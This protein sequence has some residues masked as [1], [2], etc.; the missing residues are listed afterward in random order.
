MKGK[1]AQFNPSNPFFKHAVGQFHDEGIDEYTHEERPTT[2]IFHESPKNVLSKNNSPDLQFTYSVNPYQGCE[3]G[4]VYCYARNSHTYWGFSAGLDFER[5]IIV[6]D[7]VAAMLE[8]Q[9]SKVTW[10][11]QPIMLS[12][13]TDCYQPIEKDLK[14]TRGILE[15]MLKYRNPVSIITKNA[16]ILRDSDLLQALA[17]KSLVHVYFSITTLDESLRAKLEPRTATA[18]K[19]LTAIRELSALGVPVGIM[20]AP[21]I[22]GLN[23]TEIPAV[24]K[25][26]S[27]HGALAAGYTVVRL[28][29]QI[30]EIFEDWVK[31][32]FADRAEKTMNQIKELHGGKAN[33]TDWGRRLHGAGNYALMIDQLFQKSRKKHFGDKKMPPLN[34]NIFRKGG[35]YNLFET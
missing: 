16:L 29:G 25:S 21:I 7:K 13:N 9:L 28:N 10:K 23:D 30:K 8:A 3:H 24:L 1:G 15:V 11:P 20:N 6:K 4:C 17:E 18:S 2:T 27:D 32:S 5:K 19:K 26:A 33:D 22:P 35:N 12:G 34:L 31:K 14:L